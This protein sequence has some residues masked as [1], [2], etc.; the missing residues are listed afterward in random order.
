MA[1]H[2]TLSKLILRAACTVIVAY[3]F[4]FLYLINTPKVSLVVLLF[5]WYLY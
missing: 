3:L 2:G 4:I 5:S 1:Y